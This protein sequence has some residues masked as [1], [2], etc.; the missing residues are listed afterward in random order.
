M[1]TPI[2]VLLKSNSTKLTLNSV[3]KNILIELI[4]EP[5]IHLTSLCINRCYIKSKKMLFKD[6]LEKLAMS[7]ISN[8]SISGYISYNNVVHLFDALSKFRYLKSL[9]LSIDS[10]DP[11]YTEDLIKLLSKDKLT[12]FELD[13]KS[14]LNPELLNIS[15]IIAKTKLKKLIFR[16]LDDIE[17]EYNILDILKNNIT[18]EEMP[19]LNDGLK[20]L[21]NRNKIIQYGIKKSVIIFI[22]IRRFRQGLM[23]LPQE[24]IVMIAKYLYSTRAELVWLK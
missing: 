12:F 11:Q 19:M 4:N 10:T 21:A 20:K 5:F 9:T 22:A 16:S 1:Y 24:I 2:S 7:N 8:F 17:C 14:F 23:Y 13:S 3:D 6:I 15:Q 18:I